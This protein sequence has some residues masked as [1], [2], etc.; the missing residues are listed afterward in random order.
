MGTNASSECDE[1][2]ASMSRDEAEN[3]IFALVSL[4]STITYLAILIPRSIGTAV[5]DVAFVA[6]LAWTAAIGAAVGFG[7]AAVLRAAWPKQGRVRDERD[8]EIV[9]IGQYVGSG[10]VTIGAMA[11]LVLSCLEVDRYWVANSL[12]VGFLLGGLF[13]ALTK[14]GAYH[15]EYPEI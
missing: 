10:M 3:W 7:A 4:V 11:A 13:T 14:V 15:G 6:P 9:L 1:E 5:T 8:K 2:W 12:F